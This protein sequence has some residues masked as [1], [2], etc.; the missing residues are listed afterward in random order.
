M[1]AFSSAA[2]ASRLALGPAAPLQTPA[3]TVPAPAR[4][5]IRTT[6]Y[7]PCFFSLGNSSCLALRIFLL[8]HFLSPIRALF[9]LVPPVLFLLFFAFFLLTL[10]V[11]FLFCL[12][13]LLLVLPVLFLFCLDLL[14]LF[15]P[16]L[17]RFFFALFLLVLL[18]YSSAP[19]PCVFSL[20][21]WNVSLKIRRQ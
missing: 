20:A 7:F 2:W 16:V 11:L 3:G 6:G 5:M 8:P 15:L 19:F 18:S 4:I 14:L 12:D 9:L 13:L 21:L 10:L 1:L 17:F